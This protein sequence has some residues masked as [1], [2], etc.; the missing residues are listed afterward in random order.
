MAPYFV[1]IDNMFR[2]GFNPKLRKY[3]QDGINVELAKLEREEANA[4]AKKL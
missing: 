1:H 3:V 2:L 4:A